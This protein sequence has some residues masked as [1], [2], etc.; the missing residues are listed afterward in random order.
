MEYIDSPTGLV[1]IPDALRDPGFAQCYT[2]K[3]EGDGVSLYFWQ[4]SLD[5][6]SEPEGVIGEVVAHIFMSRKTFENI[7][8]MITAMIEMRAESTDKPETDAS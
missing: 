5:P 2:V 7:P 4:P 6:G 3:W 8:A 1:L